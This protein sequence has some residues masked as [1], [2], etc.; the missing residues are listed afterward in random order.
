MKNI[1]PII[2]IST[3]LVSCTQYKYDVQY[4]KC[5]GHTGS[6]TY[7]WM[8]GPFIGDWIYWINQLFFRWSEEFPQI[9]NVCGIT[10]TKTE[11]TN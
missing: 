4:E 10:Y 6:I 2:L 11:L 9:V 1:I 5:N 7:T 8:D 3:F